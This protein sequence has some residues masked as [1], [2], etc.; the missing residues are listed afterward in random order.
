MDFNVHSY[1]VSSMAVSDE[2]EEDRGSAPISSLI[3]Q[4]ENHQVIQRSR[5]HARI[6]HR[7]ESMCD[8]RE[9]IL[10][11]KNSIECKMKQ[12]VDANAV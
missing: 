7:D 9:L 3:R 1:F 8:S 11:P 12:A 2:P 4:K 6:L 10:I 5:T